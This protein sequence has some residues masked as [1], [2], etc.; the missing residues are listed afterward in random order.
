[1]ANPTQA[2]PDPL[3][4][5]ELENGQVVEADGSTVADP[6]TESQVPAVLLRMTPGRAHLLSHVLD[7]WCRISLVFATLRSSEVTERALAW[8]LEMG[9]AA[10]GDADAR[11][12]PR[13]RP[14][15]PSAA[16]R[17]AA[18]AV[19]RQREPHITPVQAVAVIDA[20]ARWLGESSGEDLA[21]ALLQ[22]TS[23]DPLTASFVYLALIEPAGNDL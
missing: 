15:V 8:T 9:A 11:S 20:A 2:C 13:S 22:T 3:F 19:L 23:R 4:R 10:L 6:A 5:A 17:L 7:D 21:Q 14:G 18:V 12:C 16:Q 1:M